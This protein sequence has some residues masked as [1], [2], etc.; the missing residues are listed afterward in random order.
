MLSL[1]LPLVQEGGRRVAAS[2]WGVG[3][4]RPPLTV[5]LPTERSGQALCPLQKAQEGERAAHNPR[6]KGAPQEHNAASRHSC[7]RL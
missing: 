6:E 5:P 7:H 2:Q 1:A 3:Q 4:L